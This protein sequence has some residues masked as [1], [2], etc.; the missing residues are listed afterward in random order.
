MARV[1]IDTLAVNLMIQRKLQE[2]A[3]IALE[4]YTAKKLEYDDPAYPFARHADQRSIRDED[5]QSVTPLGAAGVR[6]KVDAP[7]ASFIE[8]GNKPA[9]G[10]L[11]KP[12]APKRFLTLPSKGGGNLLLTSVNPYEGTNRLW[13]SVKEAF[14]GIAV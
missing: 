13:E 10:G 7:G 6:I 14:K 8:Y 4:I 9:G 11:I 1:E 3:R 12:K 5:S 2:R